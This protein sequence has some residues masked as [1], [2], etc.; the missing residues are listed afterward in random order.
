MGSSSPSPQEWTH[1]P[2]LSFLP[3]PEQSRT[4]TLCTNFS[5]ADS[6]TL[7]WHPIFNAA[8]EQA[9]NCLE[10]KDWI[11][12]PPA[13]PDNQGANPMLPNDDNLVRIGIEDQVM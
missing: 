6:L 9:E 8:T 12:N 11:A 2:I 4:R 1:C 3:E 13:R 10:I 7:D 5:L